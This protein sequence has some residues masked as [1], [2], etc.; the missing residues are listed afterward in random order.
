MHYFLIWG[1]TKFDLDLKKGV[2]TIIT[3]YHQLVTIQ[4]NMKFDNSNIENDFVFNN[5]HNDDISLYEQKSDDNQ[6]LCFSYDAF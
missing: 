1:N 4:R 3:T 2:I 5:N 6:T